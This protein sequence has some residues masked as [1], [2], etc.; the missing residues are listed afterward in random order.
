MSQEVTDVNVTYVSPLL[1]VQLQQL[2]AP[3]WPVQAGQSRALG[4]CCQG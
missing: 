3:G 1:E 4:H 2:E